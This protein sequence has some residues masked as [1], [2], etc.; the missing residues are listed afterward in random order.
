MVDSAV[1]ALFSEYAPDHPVLVV[2][3]HRD[4]LIT[5][6][7]SLQRLETRDMTIDTIITSRQRVQP[8]VRLLFDIIFLFAATGHL[9]HLE[10]IRALAS[11][12]LRRLSDR[13]L[14]GALPNSMRGTAA[15]DDSDGGCVGA[16][17]DG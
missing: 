9:R 1:Q 7:V 10:V 2:K 15:P 14:R 17:G 11:S 12:P 16:C 5:V 6:F 3:E 13:S 4:Q 8:S